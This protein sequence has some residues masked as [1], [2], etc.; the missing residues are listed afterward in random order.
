MPTPTH[1]HCRGDIN[2]DG[3]V[4]LDDV[5]RVVRALYS[6]PG[7]PRWNPAADINR[8]GTVDPF[9]LLIVLG[10]LSDDDCD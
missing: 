3:H 7:N 10:S 5:A 2:N 8:N 9:D 6:S 1:G 4:G